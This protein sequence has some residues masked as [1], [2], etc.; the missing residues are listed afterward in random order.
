MEATLRDLTLKVPDGV[1]IWDDLHKRWF[2]GGTSGEKRKLETDCLH[3]FGEIMLFGEVFHDQNEDRAWKGYSAIEMLNHLIMVPATG[4]W[5]NDKNQIFNGDFLENPEESAIG[6][7]F[8]SFTHGGFAV[9]QDGHVGPLGEYLRRYT[10]FPIEIIG[11]I[12]E[13]PE[14]VER[15]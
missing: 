2:Q 10:V 15:M 11:N 6:F 5:T 1:R 8:Y 9:L 7:V 3:F 13:N 12:F 14:L 4:M